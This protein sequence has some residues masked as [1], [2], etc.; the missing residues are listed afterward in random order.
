MKLNFQ[1]TGNL[2]IF[3]LILK[4]LF[5]I[6]NILDKNKNYLFQLNIYLII[7]K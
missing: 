7:K 5:G 6:D 3:N 1:L 2:N 4:L